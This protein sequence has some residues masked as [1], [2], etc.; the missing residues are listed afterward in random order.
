MFVILFQLLFSDEGGHTFGIEHLIHAS[1]HS[2]LL[3]TI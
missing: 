1:P 2:V 3:L